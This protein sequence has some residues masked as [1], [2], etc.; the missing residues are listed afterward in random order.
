MYERTS[1]VR[2]FKFKF[3][4]AIYGSPMVGSGPYISTH[5]TQNVVS[6]YLSYLPPSS[7]RALRTSSN[8]V[9]FRLIFLS[10]AD[11]RQ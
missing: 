2:K 11:G 8:D 9:K 3:F 10:T 4:T 1:T 6:A 5:K 7:I